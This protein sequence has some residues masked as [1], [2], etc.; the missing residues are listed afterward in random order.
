MPKELPPSALHSPR[1]RAPL[2]VTNILTPSKKENIMTPNVKAKDPYMSPLPVV[3]MKPKVEYDFVK[4]VKPVIESIS[5]S[6]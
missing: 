6:S 5:L 1:I 2:Q 4:T 3:D